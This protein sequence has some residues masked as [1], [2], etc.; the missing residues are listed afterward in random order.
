[1][2]FLVGEGFLANASD[3]ENLKSSEYL[4]YCGFFLTEEDI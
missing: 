3:I 1:M 4:D 2:I